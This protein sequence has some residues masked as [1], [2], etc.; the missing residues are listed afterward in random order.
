MSLKHNPKVCWFCQCLK[1]SDKDSI[2]AILKILEKYGYVDSDWWS[3]NEC[4]NN[5][6]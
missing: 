1:I 4:P 3:E 2:I 6:S 5:E